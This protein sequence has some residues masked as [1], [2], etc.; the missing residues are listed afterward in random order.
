MYRSFSETWHGFSK[1]L[2]AM[3]EGQWLLFWLFLLG[4]WTFFLAP[5]VKWLWVSGAAQEFVLWRI[6]VI[7][8]IRFIV[9]L[10]LRTSWLSALLHPIGVALVMAIGLRSW[11]L[12]RGRGVEWKGRTYKVN[13]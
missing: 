7:V 2:R 3:F 9:T 1:N 13:S 10:R 8:G 11:W 12:S 6:A 4:L 5:F